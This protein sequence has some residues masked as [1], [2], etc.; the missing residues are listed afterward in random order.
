MADSYVYFYS[1]R[2]L[3]VTTVF[4]NQNVFA[5]GESST[6]SLVGTNEATVYGSGAFSGLRIDDTNKVVRFE[7][8]KTT[9]V[10]RALSLNNASLQS[11]TYGAAW[12]LVLGA[13]ASQDVRLVWVSDSH[14]GG[15]STI[16]VQSRRSRDEGNNVNWVFPATGSLIIVR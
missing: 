11:T 12:N 8:G 13:G 2:T 1:N 16:R 6:V 9:L 4:S 3:A 7:A 5:A 10:Q 14:A 15:G